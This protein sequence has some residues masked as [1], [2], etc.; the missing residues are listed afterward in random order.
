MTALFEY[1]VE[2]A[3]LWDAGNVTERLIAATE[4]QMDSSRLYETDERYGEGGHRISLLGQ[5]VLFEVNDEVRRVN[6]LAVVGQ[7]Q[8]PRFIL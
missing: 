1:L 6:I 7:L 8:K 4:R 3:S 2:N 5:H